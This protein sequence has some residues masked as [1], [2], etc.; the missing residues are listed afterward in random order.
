MCECEK[1]EYPHWTEGIAG[2]GVVESVVRITIADRAVLWPVACRC[3]PCLLYP[4]PLFLLYY[5]NVRVLPS[6]T[7]IFRI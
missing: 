2:R 6:S 3:G 4:A 1:L 7:V 5:M